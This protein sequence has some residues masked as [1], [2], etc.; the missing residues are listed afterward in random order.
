[1]L[2]FIVLIDLLDSDYVERQ[3]QSDS[4]AEFSEQD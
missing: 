4:D 3:T 1:M 2:G